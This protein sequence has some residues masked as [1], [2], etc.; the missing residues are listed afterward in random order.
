[1]LFFIFTYVTPAIPR[2]TNMRVQITICT[3]TYD[4]SSIDLIVELLLC[5]WILVTF[6]FPWNTGY[7]ATVPGH[8]TTL[9]D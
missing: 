3:G 4:A 7:K 9:S 2:F 6:S 8:L 1:M 5:L